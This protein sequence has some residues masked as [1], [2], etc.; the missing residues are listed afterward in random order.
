MLKAVS[1]IKELKQFIRG[2]ETEHEIDAI[3]I[4]Y[5]HLNLIKNVNEVLL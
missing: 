1:E 5:T 3:A 2:N 4:G